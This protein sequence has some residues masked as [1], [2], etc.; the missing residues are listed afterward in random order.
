VLKYEVVLS[1]DDN[2]LNECDEMCVFVFILSRASFRLKKVLAN[3]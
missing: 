1:S 2:L 3:L